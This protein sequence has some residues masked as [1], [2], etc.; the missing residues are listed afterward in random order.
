MRCGRDR[1]LGVDAE[2][3]DGGGLEPAP[4]LHPGGNSIASEVFLMLRFNKTSSFS[5]S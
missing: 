1:R 2:A 5:M 3:T 4:L